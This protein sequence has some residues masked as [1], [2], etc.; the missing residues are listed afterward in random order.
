MMAISVA[1]PSEYRLMTS[2]PACE[3]KKQWDELEG[4]SIVSRYEGSDGCIYEY[5]SP[6]SS[7]GF[8]RQVVGRLPG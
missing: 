3:L 8:W 1:K 7:N 2:A 5:V 6:A 4:E